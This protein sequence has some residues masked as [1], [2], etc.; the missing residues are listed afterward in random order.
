MA[1]IAQRGPIP[2]MINWAIERAAPETSMILERIAPSSSINHTDF[3]KFTKP[4][5]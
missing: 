4:V 1:G 3:K 2:R 5:R